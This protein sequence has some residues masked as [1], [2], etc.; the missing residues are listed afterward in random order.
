VGES[1]SQMGT[2]PQIG[3]EN[4]CNNGAIFCIQS[5]SELYPYK[6]ELKQRI[7]LLKYIIRYHEFYSK[8]KNDKKNLKT[9]KKNINTKSPINDL[10]NKIELKIKYFKSDYESPSK[11]PQTTQISCANQDDDDVEE[12]LPPVEEDHETDDFPVKLTLF[13]N[14]LT[15]AINEFIEQIYSGG[16]RGGG[17]TEEEEKITV[18]NK[19]V[20]EIA[21]RQ[22]EKAEK[23]AA[24]E[25]NNL[26]EIE[27]NSDKEILICKIKIA[28]DETIKEI[29][30]EANKTKNEIEKV[31]QESSPTSSPESSIPSSPKSYQQEDDSQET[32]IGSPPKRELDIDVNRSFDSQG[33]RLST[34]IKKPK[35]DPGYMKSTTSSYA[36]TRK[37]G[38]TSGRNPQH[39]STRRKNKKS[40]KRKTIKKRKM[41]KRNKTRRQRK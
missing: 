2:P 15:D 38:G 6:C 24:I 23:D 14:I 7:N 27:L 41:H 25:I 40:P 8:I 36:K 5:D 12:V 35:Q 39:K 28:L 26:D 33:N 32:T 19:I 29:R 13:G 4:Y 17:P 3:G 11:T 9:L 37:N 31:L 18:S 16:Q 20:D 10:E 22:I 1:Q 30:E 34:P 21:D